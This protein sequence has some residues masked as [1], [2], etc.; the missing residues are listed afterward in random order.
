RQIQFAD[1]GFA[2][3]DR[4]TLESAVVLV[5]RVEN[6][7]PLQVNPAKVVGD[8]TGLEQRSEFLS[9]AGRVKLAALPQPNGL[10]ILGPL[11]QALYGTSLVRPVKKP[12]LR[13]RD[14]AQSLRAQRFHYGLQLRSRR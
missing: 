13:T 8:S 6:G 7:V 5:E 12:F 3:T 1:A 10:S 14:P 4:F 11:Q 9:Q 2:Q